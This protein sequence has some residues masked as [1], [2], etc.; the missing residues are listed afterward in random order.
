MLEDAVPFL[1]LISPA[2]RAALLLDGERARLRIE[3]FR[4]AE[5]LVVETTPP[6]KSQGLEKAIRPFLAKLWPDTRYVIEV[7]TERQIVFFIDGRRASTNAALETIMRSIHPAVFRYADGLKRELGTLESPAQARILLQGRMHAQFALLSRLQELHRLKP[8][9]L[10]IRVACPKQFAKSLGAQGIVVNN[11]GVT[12]VGLIQPTKADA[13]RKYREY[14]G[15]TWTWSDLLLLCATPSDR[16]G[17]ETMI[18]RLYVEGYTTL[19]RRMEREEI[20]TY[21]GTRL[22]AGSGCMPTD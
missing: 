4:R 2:T 14:F 16:L 7:D 22:T 18:H 15:D 10:R 17:F 13:E 19:L 8:G 20:A 3:F 5:G 21:F 1:T 9:E 12:M 6:S 11:D